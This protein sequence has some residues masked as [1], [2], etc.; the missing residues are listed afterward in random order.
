MKT[1]N[2][3]VRGSGVPATPPSAV[4]WT[5]L[6][7]ARLTLFQHGLGRREDDHNSPSRCGLPHSPI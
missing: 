3:M 4:G 5:G 1:Q 6:R 2:M 7:I